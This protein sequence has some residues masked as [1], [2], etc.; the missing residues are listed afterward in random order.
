MQSAEG[1]V[2][3][4]PTMG[5]LHAG[6]AALVRRARKEAG[7]R[8]LVVVSIFVNP[9]QFGPKE[10][11]SRYPRTLAA[12]RKLCAEHGADVIFFPSPEE[13]YPADFS[14]WVDEE[15]VSGPLLR[16]AYLS[17]RR[18]LDAPSQ[19]GRAR[20]REVI[21][22]TADLRPLEREPGFSARCSWVMEV[23]VSHWGHTHTRV[24]QYDGEMTI[25]PHDGRWKID[26][27]TVLDEKQADPA[28][29]T[30]PA[31]G[32]M[33]KQTRLGSE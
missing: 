16:E 9:T 7:P 31:K 15:S 2:I 20:V 3:L 27:L 24:T 10:D 14:T 4:V 8:G 19:A 1:P 12:D 21:V 26:S 17:I 22:Q 28:A 25:R 33:G 30:A 5:A 6:H 13:M 32:M 18:M 23:A 29:M 11:F